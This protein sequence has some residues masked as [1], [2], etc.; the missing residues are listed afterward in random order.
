[1]R[2]GSEYTFPMNE[3]VL[4]VEDEALVGLSMQDTLIRYGFKIP[5]V[6]D[7]ADELIPAVMEYRP[8]LIL[9]DIRINSFVDGVDA[10]E[11]IRLVSDIPVVYVTA[12]NDPATRGRAAKTD[13]MGYLVKPVE[14]TTLVHTVKSVLS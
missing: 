5:R 1:M 14:E 8:D 7:N 9:M 2:T 11:R 10:A 4:I 3:T 13:P 6:I 12:H